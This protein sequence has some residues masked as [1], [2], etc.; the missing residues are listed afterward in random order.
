M[1]FG[2][3]NKCRAAI[4]SGCQTI[5][6]SSDQQLVNN[7]QSALMLHG[8]GIRLLDTLVIVPQER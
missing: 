4:P 6:H 1:N 8:P 3:A 5:S 2:S 7:R